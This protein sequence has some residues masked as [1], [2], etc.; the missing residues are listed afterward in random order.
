ARGEWRQAAE[1]FRQLAEEPHPSREALL[2]V[3]EAS[4]R[5]GEADA[6]ERYLRRELEIRP[7][8]G[9]AWCRLVEFAARRGAGQ[10]EI[11]GLLGETLPPLADA[12]WGQRVAYLMGAAVLD[13]ASP[14]GRAALA[15][16]SSGSDRQLAELAGELVQALDGATAGR[17]QAT[18][19]PSALIGQGLVGSALGLLQ[20]GGAEGQP[21]EAMALRG[22]ALLKLGR[23]D[24]AKEYVG[25]ARAAKPEDSLVQFT[26]AMLLKAQGR[27]E[28][29]ARV[30]HSA[31]RLDS[32]N[33]GIWAE[34]ANLLFDL[35]DY[36]TGEQAL[37]LAVAAAPESADLRLAAAEF[38]ADR[39]FRLEEALLESQ[40]AVRLSGRRAE[41]LSALGWVLHLSGRSEEAWR[42]LEEAV[43]V[44]PES[45]SLRYRLGS[46]Y[47]ALGREAEA[48]EQ[49]MM[50]AE[51][52]GSG[53]HWKR[54]MAALSGG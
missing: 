12:R 37:K 10:E 28:E 38:Y 45:A 48:R 27:K 4:S 39:Q 24:E 36:S 35:G 43:A 47:D 26:E 7:G 54:A 52:D 51:L 11:G 41:S 13:P 6:A 25:R 29:A 30:L 17:G 14:Q 34:L 20:R 3:A 9:E 18:D 50:V 15:K 16:A 46:V 44:S 2:A 31:S 8:D 33:P 1:A 5:L 21:A 23:V 19:L 49:Y 40:E 42:P 53:E 32:A 22:Y